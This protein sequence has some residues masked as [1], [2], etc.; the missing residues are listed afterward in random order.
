MSP[1][2]RVDSVCPLMGSI[3]GDVST[4]EGVNRIAEQIKEK[5]QV[6]DTLINCAGVSKP[7]KKPIKDHNDCAHRAA[8]FWSFPLIF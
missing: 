3:Q 1:N 4:K 2:G 7:W 8:S 6:V 5:E